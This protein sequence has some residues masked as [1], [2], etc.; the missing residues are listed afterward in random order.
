MTSPLDP[1]P[2]FG[3]RSPGR[4]SA[5]ADG[6]VGSEI[7]K[8]AADIRAAM[9]AGDPVCNLTVGDFAPAQFRIPARSRQ[10]IVARYAAGETNY[11]PSDGVPTLREAVRALL[12]AAARPRL[13]GRR[14][15]SSPAARGRSST[16]PTARSSIP[17]DRVVYPVPSWNNNHY[18]HLTGAV[19]RAR[20]VRARDRVPAHARA[21]RAAPGRGAPARALLAAQPDRHAVRRRAAGRRS[22]T[23]SSRRTRAAARASGRCSCCT[24]R[25]TGCSPSARRAHV[26]PPGAAAGDGAATPI[27]VD[28][29]SKAFAATGLRVGWARRTARRDRAHERPPRPRR[30]LGAAAGA[31]RDGDAARRRRGDGRP[32]TATMKP[33]VE[34]RLTALYDGLAAMRDAGPAGATPSRRGRR[35][36]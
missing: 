27:F 32:T 8:I 23:R 25:S 7:L 30:R 17:G 1:T 29:I 34:Q 28:G 6:L 31:G 14:R 11:P 26:T 10:A 9:A 13:P 21:A 16:A 4:V 12:R 5:M 18:V 35:S 2:H 36:T 19:R 33:G 24:T 3:P 15:S 20:R 22:A